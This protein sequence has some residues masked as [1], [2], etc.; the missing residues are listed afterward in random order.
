MRFGTI[1]VVLALAMMVIG[2]LF[3][4]M[5][6][7]G[8]LGLCYGLAALGVSLPARSGQVSFGH[9]MFACVSAYTVAFTAKA[10]PQLD[11]LLL[12]VWSV[13]LGTAFSAVLGLFMVRYRGIFFGMLNLAVSMVIV[14]LLGKLYALTGGSDGIRVDRPTFLG[15]V[16]ER[17]EFETLL[18]TFTLLVSVG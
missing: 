3:P 16:T 18:L 10:F 17:S 7:I 1:S 4:W 13:G 12:I 2:L 5:K 6:T 9:A 8:I 15:F 14:A 11:G